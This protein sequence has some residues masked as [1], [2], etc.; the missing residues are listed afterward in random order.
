MLQVARWYVL[1]VAVGTGLSSD[2][3]LTRVA[4]RNIGRQDIPY[5]GLREYKLRNLRLAK[6]ATVLARVTYAPREGK[7]F[8][9]LE[10]SGS[11]MLTRIV[12]RL[13]VYEADE[14]G[15]TNH[16][17]H[18]IGPS[19]YQARLRGMEDK[20]GRVCYVLDLTPKHN[21]RYLIKGTLWV[22]PGSYGIVRLEGLASSNISMW[23]GAPRIT[24]EFSEVAGF[25]L[26]SYMRAVS[27]GFLLGTSEL[28][29]RYTDYRIAD[30]DNT[31]QGDRHLVAQPE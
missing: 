22:D 12:E 11:A 29:I 7:H 31:S 10:R 3:I 19:N 5:S 23:V 6:E 30:L 17:E 26:P 24:E 1:A 13:L 21:S 25:W 28:E 18:G 14:S 27:S 16:G 15:P 8:T 9:V 4:D 2:E 20:D